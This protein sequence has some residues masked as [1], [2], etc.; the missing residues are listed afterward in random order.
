[1]KHNVT[2]ALGT[3]SIGRLML[4][5]A[6]P[7]MVALVVNSLY[8]MVDQIFIGQGVG[9]LGNAATNVILPMM[10]LLVSLGEMIGNGCAAWMSLK[11]GR[12]E[13]KEAA[14]GVGNA[15]VLTMAVGVLLLVVNLLC[16]EPICRL[17]G[18]TDTVLPYAMGYGRIIAL[19]Y[20]CSAV[21]CT[22]SSLLRADGRPHITMLGLLMGC[23]TNFVLDPLFIFVFDWGVEGAAWATLI[24]QAL[25][26]VYFLICL[27]RF[28]SLVFE[29]A[30]LVPRLKTVG[31]VLLLGLPSLATQLSAV[32]VIYVV[33]HAL[34]TYG[35]LSR[36]GA[37]IPLAALG[38]TMKVNQLVNNLVV[39]LAVGMQPIVGYNYGCG[40]Y[41]RVKRTLRIALISATAIMTAAW[42]LFQLAPDPIVALF[43][44]ESALYHEF[45]VKCLQI[46]LLLCWSVG[47][48]T[49][50]GVFFQALGKPAQSS[51]LILARQLVFRIPGV[52]CLS[53]VFGIEGPLWAGPISDGLSLILAMAL[54]LLFWKRIFVPVADKGASRPAGESQ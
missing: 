35:A 34:V 3:Q 28:R 25:N 44:S 32:F 30:C 52:L 10:L 13:R 26:A 16:L 23:G 6:V 42:L 9:Y 40:R 1:M 37:D 49:V 46:Y 4:R 36:Y 29:R 45:A 54:M 11:L 53:R 41:E 14:C 24:G 43:G 19:G 33:N 17:F 7:S 12:G 51:F 27:P 47:I 21:C 8:N 50:T 15:I 2:D 20:P 39:G 48:S 38:V 18:A 22:V 31:S 5:F